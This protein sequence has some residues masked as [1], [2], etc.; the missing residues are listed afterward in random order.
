M[1]EDHYA[2]P[3][4]TLTFRIAGEEV[5][6]RR[7]RRRPV[8]PLLLCLAILVVTFALALLAEIPIALPKG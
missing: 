5:E 6:Y 4:E 3:P 7:V 2:E 1:I 8:G